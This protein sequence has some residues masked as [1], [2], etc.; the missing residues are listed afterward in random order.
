MR[1]PGVR[2]NSNLWIEKFLVS[3]NFVLRYIY[4]YCYQKSTI[5]DKLDK[6]A[7]KTIELQIAAYQVCKWKQPW[8]RHWWG[9]GGCGWC[10]CC[11]R[12]SPVRIANQPRLGDVSFRMWWTTSP[13]TPAPGSGATSLGD[14]PGAPLKVGQ[15]IILVSHLTDPVVLQLEFT[16]RDLPVPTWLSVSQAPASPSPHWSAG[17]APPPVPGSQGS[18]KSVRKLTRVRPNTS[19]VSPPPSLTPPAGP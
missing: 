14:M 12:L 7:T 10:W 1:T 17:R 3:A 15:E 13:C 4:F 19:G 2:K 16:C 9:C 11:S 18:S 8:V 5:V 6:S